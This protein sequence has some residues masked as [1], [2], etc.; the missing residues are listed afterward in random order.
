MTLVFFWSITLA[1]FPMASSPIAHAAGII[2]GTAF[3]DFNED[4]VQQITPLSGSTVVDRGIGGITVRA[5][6]AAGIER[7]SA[8]T[9][10]LGQ[11]QITTSGTGP[12]RIEFTWDNSSRYLDVAQKQFNPLFGLQPGPRNADSVGGS[13]AATNSSSTVQFVQNGSTS[14][15]NL[16]VNYPSDYCQS[17]PKLVS[18]RV[19]VG[20]PSSVPNGDVLLTFP[21]T[22][23]GKAT[24]GGTPYASCGTYKDIG[25]TWG[26]TYQRSTGSSMGRVFAAAA[27]KRHSGLGP[28]GLNGIYV[29]DPN[30][31]GSGTSWYGGPN[32]VI[33]TINAGSPLLPRGLTG[34]PAD[35]TPDIE[36]FG[37]VGKVG[38]GDIDISDDDKT[39]YVTNLAD[40]KLYAI[41]IASV[42]A[43]TP[44]YTP[45]SYIIPPQLIC[46]NGIGR[47]WAIKVYRGFVYVGYVCTAELPGGT[48]A[49]LSAH[50]YAL[51]PI[52]GTWVAEIINVPLDYDKGCTTET[53]I[54]CQWEPWTDIWG[55]AASPNF[56]DA[57]DPT[58][59]GISYSYRPMPLLSDIEFDAE[60]YLLLGFLDRTGHMLGHFNTSPNLNA[61]DQ[62]VGNGGGDLLI[63]APPSTPGGTYTLE[64]DGKV[65]TRS[66]NG[67]GTSNRGPGGPN[68]GQGPHNPANGAGLGDEFF[69]EDYYQDK[70]PANHSETSRGGLAYLPGS[71]EVTLSVMDPFQADSGGVAWYDTQ[72]GGSNRAYEIYWDNNTHFTA[73]KGNGIGDMELLCDAAPIEIGNRVWFDANK[74]GIQDAD[75]AEPPIAGVTV[76]LYDGNNVL[77]GTSVTNAN[78]EWY[79]SSALG[80]SSAYARYG[81]NLLPNQ[82][83]FIR[84]D[85]AQNYAAQGPLEKYTLTIPNV[86]PKTDRITNNHN[87]K[88]TLT[89]ANLAIGVGNYPTITYTTGGAGTNDHTLDIGF[90]V[91]PTAI[92]LTSFSANPTAGGVLVRWATAAEIDTYGFRLV[93]SANGTRADAIEITNAIIPGRGRGQGANYTWIDTTAVANVAY[94]YWLVEVETNGTITDY[95]PTR[96]AIQSVVYQLM[97]PRIEH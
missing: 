19:V 46:T 27:L 18:N 31:V 97:L 43:N 38:F 78:G 73:G 54:G 55:T 64:A 49:D 39:L 68:S 50:V 3:R 80:T 60:G 11:Y 8:L 20:D 12:Y 9:N 28:L 14:N 37:L 16:A 44:G 47:P 13:G 92:A 69:W 94:T 34:N 26:L 87:S 53:A 72:Q 17:D 51:D 81:I 93:R 67:T 71:Q 89:D 76:H 1:F 22:A 57:K 35:K 30:V 25:S 45:T 61:L 36:A 88:A 32:G 21:Y 74:N 91:K 85:N 10:Q 59:A 42:D 58:T 63:A 66:S 75:A 7:G 83:Y 29:A 77:L 95:G 96:V 56:A 33:N 65:G 48:R 41:D 6:D 5:Y 86:D 79:F 70:V 84:L 4:G 82:P 23:S 90:Y 15:V 40:R 62:V 24:N 2:G 52:T